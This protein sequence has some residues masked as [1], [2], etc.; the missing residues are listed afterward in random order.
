MHEAAEGGAVE[1]LTMLMDR[2]GMDV[3]S[4]FRNNTVLITAILHKEHAA[5]KMPLERGA[6]ARARSAKGISA[7]SL[8]LQENETS[9]GQD[10]QLTVIA[11]LEHI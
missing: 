5:T 11:M 9:W 6:G 8:A 3:E 2:Y 10:H 7:M 1:A 4:P